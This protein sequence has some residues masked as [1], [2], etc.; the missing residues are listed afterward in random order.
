[1]VRILAITTTERATDQES[2]KNMNRISKKSQK[3]SN[4]TQK[5]VSFWKIYSKI[6]RMYTTRRKDEDK[7]SES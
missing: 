5:N 4:V 3:C 1:M 2:N 7:Q 6:V